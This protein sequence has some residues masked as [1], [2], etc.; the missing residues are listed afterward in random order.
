MV[1]SYS[2]TLRHICYITLYVRNMGEYAG[3][4]EMYSKVFNFG[5]P[6]TRVS[7]ID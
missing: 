4:N 2:F 1:Q 3:M 5:N 6:P 7:T